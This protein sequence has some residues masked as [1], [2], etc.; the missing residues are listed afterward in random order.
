MTVKRFC[1]KLVAQVHNEKLKHQNIMKKI[2][3]FYRKNNYGVT[4]EYIHPESA[5]DQKIIQQL[6]GKK[7]IC[8]TVRELLRDLS[9]GQIEFSEVIAP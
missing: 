2:I 7:T 9:A 3:K 5:A 1:A 6:T 4:V 8:A